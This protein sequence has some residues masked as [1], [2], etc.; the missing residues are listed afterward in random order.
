M[1]I[2]AFRRWCRQVGLRAGE[3]AERLRL[4]TGTLE[5]WQARWRRDRIRVRARG[6]PR[7]QATREQRNL[8]LLALYLLGPGVGVPTLRSL[9]PGVARSAVCEIVARYRRVYRRRRRGL[10]HAL[11]W[12]SPGTVWAMDFTEPPLPIDGDYAYI[13]VVRDM[14]CGKLLAAVPTREATAAVVCSVLVA[15]FL[16]HGAPLVLKS[17]NGSHFVNEEVGRLLSAWRTMALLSPPH[18]PSYNGACEAGIGGLK[19]RAHDESA[20]CDRPGQWT[21]D[22]VETARLAANETARPSGI[23]APTPDQAWQSRVPLEAADRDRFA[24]TVARLRP[25]ARRDLGPG[26]ATPTQV[27]RVAITRAL[28]ERD[29]LQLRRRRFT[30]S[31]TQRAVRN[32][33]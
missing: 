10:R 30:L 27:D 11:R 2:L 13:L 3:V 5:A 29:Y 9:F 7:Q 33:K 22:D 25:E 23:A 14:A 4:R 16:A 28:I 32:F 19:T 17:D 20:R 1:D 15:L 26:P 18:T 31:I 21:C 6:R 12:T 8:L 24:A